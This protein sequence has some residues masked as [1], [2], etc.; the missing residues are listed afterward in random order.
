[1]MRT[2][3]ILSLVFMFIGLLTIS[4]HAQTTAFTYQ[5]RLQT[6]A[7]P[8][9]GNYD[10][11]FLLF[12]LPTG[13]SQIGSTAEQPSIS[14]NNG[15]FSVVL[16]FADAFNGGPRYLE[17]RVRPTGSSDY[18]TLS[19]RQQITSSPYAVRSI[20]SSTSELAQDSTSLGGVTASEYVVTTDP[21]LSDARTPQPNSFHYI[22]NSNTPQIGQFNITGGGTLSGFLSAGTVNSNNDYL[23]GFR[24]IVGIGSDSISSLYVGLDAGPLSTGSDNTFI[25]A[26]S[27][28]ENTTGNDNSF[29]GAFSGSRNINGVRNSFF[30]QAAGLFTTTGSSNSFLGS[31][32]GLNNI[33]GHNN[34]LVGDS[35]GLIIQSGIGNTIVGSNGGLGLSLG[36]FNTHIGF[37]TRQGSAEGDLNISLGSDT[38]VGDASQTL[39]NAGAIG[40]N[41][42]VNRSNSLVLGSIQGVNFAT[43][44]TFVGIGTTA[45]QTKL[46]V[47][48]GVFVTGPRNSS[49]SGN[50]IALSSESTFDSIQTFSNRPLAI[51]PIGNNVGIG[52]TAPAARLDVNG[53]IRVVTLGSAGSTGLCR[54][55]A[56][57]ISTC[58]SSLRYKNNVNSY[59]PG[60]DLINRL[61]PI[62]F[63][64]TDGGM[65]DLGLGA[66][67]VAA[68]EPLLVTYGSNGEVEGVKYDRIGVVLINAVKEQQ[69]QIE[70]K[71]KENSEMKEQITRQSAE[72][73]ALKALVCA[74]NTEAP[75]CS[76][77]R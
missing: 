61:K 75:V 43:A 74:Q 2:K 34:T 56:N 24:R 19:P 33:G 29:V 49:P 52:T 12:D 39:T 42:Q 13:G 7:I 21:R 48:G 46:H 26:G 38:R 18:E 10:M 47:N 6:G 70:A 54:N 69:A 11:E 77:D 55:A 16:D 57:L 41:A 44:D 50:G 20:S 1:M 58:S 25:G 35:A 73:A 23:L 51:N 28:L 5:G 53:T 68:I 9:T 4:S 14:V 3:I 45:P 40:S 72:I 31:R 65:I 60:M 62:S 36:S 71:K 37:G 67:D 22:H 17:I 66:E 8:A 30:G 32:A 15:I 64:W 59:R 76:K 27:G 63:N